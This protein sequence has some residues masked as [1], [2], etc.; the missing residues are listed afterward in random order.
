MIPSVLARQLEQGIRDF[1]GATFPLASPYFDGMVDDFLAKP[2]NV[3]KGPFFQ[4]G[5]PFKH[6]TNTTI[7]FD[8][9]H[10]DGFIPWAHQDIAWQRLGGDMPQ[11]TLVA[12][13]TGS[14][15]TECF[16]YPILDYCSRHR[17]SGIKAIIL[18]PMNALADDQA[19]RLAALI[20]RQP[21]LSG[22]R[23]GV[24]TG[25]ASE[26]RIKTMGED[27]LITDR[28]TL[29]EYPPDILLTN[30]KMLDLL[31]L[32]A[33]DRGLW[34]TKAL[35]FLVVDELHSFDGAQGTDLACLVRRLRER[36]DRSDRESLA[37]I[38][39]SA[40]LGT[41]DEARTALL[42][43]ATKV[44]HATFD[45]SALIEEQRE[46]EQDFLSDAWISRV[47]LPGPESTDTMRP[48]PEEDTSPAGTDEYTA[49]I[50]RQMRLWFPDIDWT[51]DETDRLTLAE[52]LKTHGVFQNILRY[53]AGR[54]RSSDD[55]MA[56]IRKTWA[57]ARAWTDEQ[58]FLC[59]D[60][61]FALISHARRLDGIRTVPFLTVR[62]QFWMRELRRLVAGIPVPEPDSKQIVPLRLSDEIPAGDK[63]TWLP[64][65]HCRECNSVGWLTREAP[66]EAPVIKDLRAIYNGYFGESK[67]TLILYPKE[68]N[69]NTPE[70]ATSWK[71]CPVCGYLSHESVALC[72]H[73]HNN[74]LLPVWKCSLINAKGK[75]D[76]SC[77][78]CGSAGD[79]SIMGAKAASLLAAFVGQTFSN[80]FNPDKK[81]LAFSDSVQDAAHRA[82]FLTAR[83]WTFSFRTAI[84]EV[85]S[86]SKRNISLKDLTNTFL[87]HW[88]DKTGT[89]ENFVGTFLPPDMEW[90]EDYD[91]LLKEGTLP[92]GSDIM[93][94]L[95]RRLSWEIA[96]EF[97]FR[98]R[99]G[100]TLERTASAI[101]ATDG[102]LLSIAAKELAELMSERQ[103]RFR[104]IDTQSL[105]WVQLLWGIVFRMKNVGAINES[106]IQPLFSYGSTFPF[107]RMHRH[108]PSFA[109][110][111]P[112]VVTDKPSKSIHE[113]LCATD[114]RISWFEYWIDK[115]R[116]QLLKDFDFDNPAEDAEL[117]HS[118]IE[119]LLEKGIV[120]AFP[121]DDSK[122]GLVLNTS[123]L[124]ISDRVTRFRC[125]VCGN[126]IEAADSDTAT[127][128]EL[129]CLR[130]GCP[131]KYYTDTRLSS[132]YYKNFYRRGEVVRINGREH[133]GLLEGKERKILEESFISGEHPWDP[134]LLSATP[135]LEMG[136]NIG[137]LSTVFLCSVPP[138]VANYLQRVGRAGRVD[139]NANIIAMANAVPHDQYFFQSPQE[140]IEGAVDAPAIYDR[141]VAVLERHLTAYAMERWARD[142]PPHI[143]PVPK[144]LGDLIA[145]NN[146]HN[147]ELFPRAFLNAVKTHREEWLEG[148]FSVFDYLEPAGDE[149]TYLR[150][151]LSSEPAIQRTIF[152]TIN[153]CLDALSS[154][155]E[156]MRSRRNSLR[157]RAKDIREQGSL[158]EDQNRECEDLERE[159]AGLSSGV[160]KIR[161]T[162]SWQ[163]LC[164]VGILPNYAFPETGVS[165]KATFYRKNKAGAKES[166]SYDHV[167]LLRSASSALREFAP[168]NEFFGNGHRMKINRVDLKASKLETWRFCPACSHAVSELHEHFHLSDCP[169]CHAKGWADIGQVHSLLRFK[170]VYSF[171]SFRESLISDNQEDR[172]PVFYNTKLLVD[173][174]PTDP[175]NRY[176]GVS[177]NHAPIAIEFIPKATF[178]EINFGRIDGGPAGFPVAGEIDSKTGF[179]VC[180]ICGS[181]DSHNHAPDCPNR[182]K[183]DTDITTKDVIHLYHEF[184]SEAIRVVVPVNEFPLDTDIALESTIAGVYLGLRKHFGGKADH[185][186]I[187]KERSITTSGATL[188]YLVIYDSIP[189]GTGYLKDF[190]T[191]ASTNGTT[192]FFTVLEKAITS[193]KECSCRLDPDKDGCYRCVL[194]HKI[195]RKMKDVSRTM[196]IAVLERIYS[197]RE[198]IQLQAEQAFSRVDPLFDSKLEELFIGILQNAELWPVA[199][200]MSPEIFRGKTGNYVQIGTRGYHIEQQVL[201]SVHN[202]LR[203]TTRADFVFYPIAPGEKPIIVYT[204][205]YR[206]HK[207]SVAQDLSIRLAL[208]LSGQYRV[209][210]FT[211]EDIASIAEHR[212]SELERIAHPWLGHIVEPKIAKMIQHFPLSRQSW[213]GCDIDTGLVPFISMLSLAEK[214]RETIWLDK[215]RYSALSHLFSTPPNASIASLV[216]TTGIG[217]SDTCRFITR[218]LS[219]GTGHTL[220]IV[221]EPTDTNSVPNL[222]GWIVFNDTEDFSRADWNSLLELINL[223]QI[224]PRFAFTAKSTAS[225]PDWMSP[226]FQEIDS[227]ETSHTVEHDQWLAVEDSVLASWKP[228]VQHLHDMAIP[229]PEVG[230]EDIDESGL[231][232]FTAELAWPAARY[233]IL[234]PQQA[235]ATHLEGWTFVSW[236]PH[237][238]YPEIKFGGNK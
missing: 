45:R 196:A 5:L 94:K 207:D 121:L 42:D 168:E 118:A 21:A 93:D 7:P 217:F 54:A 161:R 57:P 34:H 134:N 219:Q 176:F 43:F 201:I 114:K 152:R 175:N 155:L 39:T 68:A 48:F 60:S 78:R 116:N 198:T 166:F 96:S 232:T 55:I 59:I 18:Y 47:G 53:T 186:R 182:N 1:I 10:I 117:L 35:K 202:P 4:I 135:T 125:S 184:T 165:L 197:E 154:E 101:A 97:T 70:N 63:H 213:P 214:E 22:L 148:F 158:T 61:L 29:R 190:F 237:E 37:C 216:D 86:V 110:R 123:A 138:G 167:E 49:Y 89:P 215:T 222:P 108:M 223:Y 25:S 205:G 65:I 62:T 183:T 162:E 38:G 14:G 91:A 173:F 149:Q 106:A 153:E 15:K 137:D 17:G 99:I 12:T 208:V 164:D 107:H 177:D 226:A 13:G 77:P 199:V 2:G 170:Q 50:E 178:R 103:E 234:T 75:F 151:W 105:P 140:M 211:W 3:F 185:L 136:I 179:P 188:S 67:D 74:S 163:F 160:E 230:Y 220:T 104:T 231:V 191:E 139:G 58:V 224:L 72:S 23:A 26:T 27:E 90:F 66:G 19:R 102:Q 44:F 119:V 146:N 133:T 144:T 225:A 181:L 159:A 124:Q 195:S 212:P 32:R 16:L 98:S 9:I 172:E 126:G 174:D 132:D 150:E 131:G 204:D 236:E 128:N 46:S 147:D 157:K 187:T 120:N 51:G 130:N 40:T 69:T 56:H 193:L 228:L 210:S 31:L 192:T 52:A 112:H 233:A 189:G 36:L 79:L 200:T 82:G 221:F 129:P 113:A 194:S 235:Q 28:D 206:Y 84:R 11:S 81:L 171:S 76:S 24:Y 141:A 83:A 111:S 20:A 203:A 41:G 127:V 92:S 71:L 115:C 143:D 87:Q 73:C 209:F 100:R 85:L 122:S 30:Y 229:L 95:S 142:M 180:T 145:A 238:P 169:V 80:P 227:H 64:V 156:S 6:G 109:K 8:S 218:E 88:R 33:K